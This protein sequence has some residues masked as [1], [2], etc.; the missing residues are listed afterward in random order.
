METNEGG[1]A[2]PEPEPKIVGITG[3]IGSGKSTVARYIEEMGFPIYYSDQRAKDIVNEDPFLKDRIIE[4]LGNEAYDDNG[5]YDRQFVSSVVFND[6]QLLDKLNATIHP[7]VKQD[8]E[9]WIQR[10]NSE[11]LFKETA[12]L[13][14]LGLD[15]DCYKTVLVTAEDNLRI[16]RV[17]DR[18]GKT[19]REVETIISKQMPEKDKSKRADFI[20][21]NNTDLE[22]LK[23]QTNLMMEKLTRL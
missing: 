7:A 5:F 8:F 11:F 12:L 10:Q 13:F 2:S 4:I 21:L 17:M 19:Y 18:D 6:Q 23:E 22:E 9:R 3:G 16:K 1:S 14:E 15:R 20:I